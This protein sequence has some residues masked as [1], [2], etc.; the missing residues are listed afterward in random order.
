[1]K[2]KTFSE[3]QE[4]ND[5]NKDKNKQKNWKIETHTQLT[6]KQNKEQKKKGKT[7]KKEK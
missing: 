5:D 6:L 7:G 2:K 4:K 1:M 3:R